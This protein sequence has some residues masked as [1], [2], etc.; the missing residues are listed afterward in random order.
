MPYIVT[1]IQNRTTALTPFF[2]F[3]YSAR[4]KYITEGILTADKEI[5]IDGLTITGILNFV[6]EDA[7]HTYMQD[8]TIQRLFAERVA[9]NSAN[10]ITL[11]TTAN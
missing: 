4:E 8:A 2:E 1:T 11:T 7:Y 9:Y 6:N 3:P 10:N 5:S